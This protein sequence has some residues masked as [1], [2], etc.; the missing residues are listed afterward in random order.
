MNDFKVVVM[1]KEEA[2]KKIRAIKTA[3]STGLVVSVRAGGLVVEKYAKDKVPR[4]TGN[5]SRSIH[6]EIVEVTP[7]FAAAII[8]TDVEYAA[9]V[10]FGGTIK[11]KN[12][13]YLVFKTRDGQ[14]HKVKSVTQV[15]QPYLR[16]ALDE[17]IEEVVAAM[18]ETFKKLIEAAANI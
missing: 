18:S 15:P 2:I 14:W 10:E 3:V 9:Q 16:P 11:A 17:H 1:G 6:V 12:A 4:W 13:P 5:L 7:I 8:G